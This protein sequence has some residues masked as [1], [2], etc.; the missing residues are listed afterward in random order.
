MSNVYNADLQARVAQ[1]ISKSGISQAKAAPLMGVSQT[2]LSQWRNSK[3]DNGNIEE[4]ESKLT[5]FFKLQDEH[6]AVAEKALQFSPTEGYIPT[7]IS[8]DIYKL[9]RY[10]QI[11]KGLFIAHGDAGIG[12][13]EA[14]GK[15]KH[16]NPNA[17]IYIKATP[18]T[19]SLREVLRM[20]AREL[21]VPDTL[22]S[23]DLSLAV[24]AKL[25]DTKKLVI[26]DEAQH[27]CYKAL[28]QITRWTDPDIDT[29][30]S[31]IAIVLMGNTE[32]Y[33]KMVGR[34]EA[35]FAQQFSRVK[36][37]KRYRTTSITKDDIGLLF[38]LLKEENLS[39]QHDFLFR[40][41]QSKWGIRGAVNLYNNAV[42]NE[43]I[44]YEGLLSMAREMG[45]GVM[46]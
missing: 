20:L 7:S 34:Q 41:S 10:C 12:K 9:I 19:S 46:S 15:F 11:G 18:A 13:T 29:R 42:N 6:Q 22:R 43:T 1:Y 5:E 8:E 33:N 28:E 26:I 36:M 37:N 32:I 17:T 45:I 4:V 14:A 35:Q 27:L 31:N 21:K 25:L 23:G 24:E 40:I 2:T 44:S 30:Q 16:D 38:P 39:K 3:Y